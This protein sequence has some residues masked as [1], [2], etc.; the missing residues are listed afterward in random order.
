ME[1]C[2][3]AVKVPDGLAESVGKIIVSTVRREE[4]E[5]KNVVIFYYN[6]FVFTRQ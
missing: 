4:E 1:I 6:L 3:E 5:I 2:V